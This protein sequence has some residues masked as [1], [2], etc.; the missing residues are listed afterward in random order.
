MSTKRAQKELKKNSECEQKEPQLRLGKVSIGKVS[1][2]KVRSVK[3]KVEKQSIRYFLDSH[4]LKSID[5]RFEKKLSD[6]FKANQ[7]DEADCID[8]CEYVYEYLSN[9]HTTVDDRLFFYVCLKPDVLQRFY[10][11]DKKANK[12]LKTSNW[13]EVCPV[14]NAHHKSNGI[15][16]TCPLDM[17]K[18]NSPETI[19]AAKIIFEKQKQE[20]ADS[21]AHT[22]M[23]YR[24]GAN[25]E[26]KQTTF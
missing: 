21:L 13:P 4:D 11:S 20:I 6:F 5:T 24:K 19:S 16:R 26:T 10:N 12:S 3:D 23:Y 15:L 8:Y 25:N 22:I 14:C 17:S 1:I 7:K 9:N 18:N 2:D